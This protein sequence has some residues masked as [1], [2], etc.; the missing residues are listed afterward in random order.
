[1]KKLILFVFLFGVTSFAQNS[2]SD[3][4]VFSRN[5]LPSPGATV[6]VC[7]QTA[8][9]AAS[10]SVNT[11]TITTSLNP[12]QGSTVTIVGVLPAAYNGSYKVLTTSGTNFT[13][14]NPTSGLGAG[15]VF[16]SAVV[17]S[18]TPCAP[19]AN[20]CSNNS[21]TSC[22]SPNPVTADGLGNYSFYVAPGRYT[23]QFYGSGLTPRVQTD[24]ILPC[25]PS[26]CP[27]TTGSTVTA[28]IVNSKYIENVRY[29]DQ[30]ASLQ[31]AITDACANT[32]G[33]TVY[34]PAGTYVQNSQFTLCANLYIVG[35][36][37][38]VADSVTCPT[39][40]TTTQ[41]TGDLFNITA[42]DHVHIQNLA[43][44]NIGTGGA[45][46]IHC[47][48]CRFSMFTDLYIAGP[49]ATGAIISPDVGVVSSIWNTFRNVHFTGIKTTGAMITL[50]ALNTTSQVINNNRFELVTGQGGPQGFGVKIKATG[51]SCPGGATFINE[52]YFSGGQDSTTLGGGIG[53]S[54][55]NCTFRDL[56][57]DTQTIEANTNSIVLGTGNGGFTCLACEI[58]AN[59]INGPVDNTGASGR[60][61]I[62]GNVGGAA[63]IFGVDAVG[64]IRGNGL[65][66]QAAGCTTSNINGTSPMA[67]QVAGNGAINVQTA[68]IGFGQP[69]DGFNFI[70]PLIDTSGTPATTGIIRL[71][72]GDKVC[73]RNGANSADICVSQIQTKTAV[74][75]CAT[76]ASVG[77]ICGTAV[78]WPTAFDDTAYSVSCT[79]NAITSGIPFIQS[80]ISKTTTSV[81]VVTS[82]V[83]AAAAQFAT[84]E[85]TA[86][87][88]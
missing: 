81:S 66:L 69:L 42:L 72:D 67:I 26:N 36:G 80:V 70:N 29:A 19:L 22:V 79:G 86:I 68:K 37:R 74:S 61:F 73:W 15:S 18:S 24:Q 9:T 45:T 16:G 8:I 20:L 4:I 64:N 49:W 3:G 33:G 48:G 63:Q 51:G 7:S 71:S 82:A 56:W 35:D 77:A 46:P 55:D 40:I 75:G 5:G 12:P 85:C 6:A 65:C 17:T 62:T 83:T 54:A 84:V 28:N 53:V 57:M 59:S 10:E 25:D 14:T 32:N 21:D 58:S 11:A 31:A 13:Y 50:D 76:A 52:N 1:M 30:F 27:V 88:Q 47:V 38:C 78:T 60:T 39:T 44:K 87:R 2:R 34:V 43:I 41:T 23:L